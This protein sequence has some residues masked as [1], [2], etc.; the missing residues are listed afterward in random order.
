M[1]DDLVNSKLLSFAQVLMD[2]WS[3]SQ[4]LMTKIYSLANIYYF[5]MKKNRLV[6]ETGGV[7]KYK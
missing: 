3:A 7:S 6:D 1:L 4:K 5:Q 2:S